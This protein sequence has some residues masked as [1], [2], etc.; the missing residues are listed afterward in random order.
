M[1]WRRRVLILALAAT[2]GARGGVYYVAPEGS[3]ATGDGSAAR[4]WGTLTHAAAS[5]PDDGS[6]VI[7]R[8]GVYRGRV[9]LS[10]RFSRRAVFRAEHPYRARLENSAPDE[11]VVTIFGAA[12]IE[13]A[14][15][16]ITRP[17]PEA[18]AAVVVQ[19]QQAGGFPAEEI[20]L[21]DN[22]IHDS[23][24]NDLVKVNNV[25]R[26]ILIEGNVLFNQQG[27][28][29]HIDVN[30]VTDVTI[31]DNIFFNDF[32]GSGRPDAADTGSF[33]VI[34]NSA[35]LPENRGIRVQRNIFLN[36]EG[37]PGSYFVLVGEDGQP[38]HEAEDVLIEN[39]LMIGNSRKPMRAPFGVKGARD[40]V[41]RHNT[42]VGDLPAN[43]FAMRLNREGRNPV[44]ERIWF[45]A[46]V[47][48]DP[49]G[50]MEDFSDGDRTET[51]DARLDNN[52]Y[53][54]G[55]RPLPADG[56]VLNPGD[57]ARRV[58]GDPKL[59]PQNG[60]VLPRWTGTRFR[61]GTRTIRE[62]FER[63]VMLYGAPGPSSAVIGRGDP[64]QAPE[65]DILGRPRDAAPDL[66]CFE[67]DEA[68][69]QP[70]ALT[71][72]AIFR[73]RLAPGGLATLFGSRLSIVT[74]RAYEDP[75]PRNLAAVE[76]LVSGWPA[77]LWYVSPEQI[78][79]QIPY[80]APAEAMLVVRRGGF[81][82]PERPIRIERAA[83]AIFSAGEA[84]AI[85][86]AGTSRLV[87]PQD[88]ARP[89][90]AVSIW[91]TGLG[92]LREPLESGLAAE[93]PVWAA[94]AVRVL[95]DGEPVAPLYAGAAIGF[96]GLNQINVEVPRGLSGTVRLQIDTGGARSEPVSLSVSP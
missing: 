50:T 69:P 23:F 24:N 78:N 15:F 14:G 92:L 4:P 72:A 73:P 89:G 87:T 54:N 75:L 67:V 30:G 35:G 74:A 18:D 90:E 52:L 55:G 43:A 21:R 49:A 32:A 93:R 77:P 95:F 61:S 25:A 36:W 28:D 48:A 8:D 57:D 64:A 40:V 10:R 27:H 62:E 1:S 45:F 63:L 94:E 59:P 47:W 19:I 51:R 46:N 6:T 9:R 85:T 42:V 82:A 2:A 7:V 68:P 80:E 31:R 29:E 71:D 53:W 20:V 37:S 39:N 88:P 26:R 91:L 56:D 70:V 76:V 96:A 13:L 34:K 38:F 86:H 83:P 84:P 11:R 60:L 5:I 58:I 3:D 65:D 33:I 16:E 79:F 12:N 17:G 66:G 41:F 81:T 22:I 44:N